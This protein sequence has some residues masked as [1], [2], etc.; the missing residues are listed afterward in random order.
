ML[1]PGR[2][3]TIPLNEPELFTAD[4]AWRAFV[5]AD[6]FG[7]R[8]AT[9]RFML[10]SFGLD[11]YVR[12]AGPSVTCPVLLLL[13]ER[14]R[15]ISNSGTRSFVE[16]FATNDRTVVE[17]PDAEHTLEFEDNGHP[18]VRDMESWLGAKV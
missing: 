4:P 11:L 7:L 15:I 3:F 17:Y 10:A 9:A 8:E 14:D 1:R 2:T 16:S 6:R 13:A 18:F 5:R 12:R